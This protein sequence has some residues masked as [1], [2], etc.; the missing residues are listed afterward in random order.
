MAETERGREDRVWLVIER[1][2]LGGQGDEDKKTFQYGNQCE[3]DVYVVTLWFQAGNQHR[4]SPFGVTQSPA[5]LTEVKNMEIHSF[6]LFP[7][8]L[9]FSRE[10]APWLFHS[11]FV[12]FDLCGLQ[13]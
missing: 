6:C 3:G 11:L 8:C 12:Q 10:W 4:P 1:W 7:P 5:S 13:L 9:I 2:Q